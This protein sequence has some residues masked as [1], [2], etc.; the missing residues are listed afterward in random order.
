MLV[1]VVASL[2]QAR[3]V[4]LNPVAKGDGHVTR[5]PLTRCTE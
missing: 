3:V 4:G 2:G 5:V 1:E